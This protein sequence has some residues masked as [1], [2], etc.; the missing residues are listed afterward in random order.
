MTLA[1]RVVVMNG[2]H[3]E[4]MG[5]PEDV[6]HGPA[7]LFVAGFIG[8]P[9]MNLIPARCEGGEQLRLANADL[10]RLPHVAASQADLVLGIR[11]EDVEITP[12]TSAPGRVT[13]PATIDVVEPLGAD[14]LVFATMAGH[15]VSARVRPDVR[16][17]RGAHIHL[18]FDIDRIH[19]FDAATGRRLVS[20]PPSA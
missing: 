12:K 4:Q 2:G 3:I 11:P 20:Q 14:T 19:L 8:A 7:S 9:A 13:L 15:G 17:Q 10:I 18:S 6:Y 5:T 1:D 16:P